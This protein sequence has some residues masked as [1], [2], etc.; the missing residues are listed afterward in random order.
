MAGCCCRCECRHEAEAREWREY[1][2]GVSRYNA[3]EVME[4]ARE[5]SETWRQNAHND[6][7]L[8]IYLLREAL[9]GSWPSEEVARRAYE[10][11]IASGDNIRANELRPVSCL[12]FREED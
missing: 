12:A 5:L 10:K 11:M 3:R 6:Y 1:A 8:M 7:W 2:Q 9:P 4:K